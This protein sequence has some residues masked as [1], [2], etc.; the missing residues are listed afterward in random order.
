MAGF[1]KDGN[2][3]P[4][5][6][7]Y[8][9]NDDI[10][11]S[12]TGWS[13]KKV[14]DKLASVKSIIRVDAKPTYADGT[15]TYVKDGT[16]YTTTDHETWFYYVVNDELYKT[17]FI[18]GVEYTKLDSSVNFDDFIEKTDIVTVLD[19]T[20]TNKQVVGAK[21]VYEMTKDNN[22]KT[23]TTLDQLGLS[24]GCDVTEIVNTM[25]DHS[26]AEIGCYNAPNSYGL[27]FVTGL[28]N[29]ESNF[30]LTIRKYNLHR[31][32]I[33][34]KSSASGAVMNDLYIGGM[35][36]GGT[37]V[38][39]RNVCTTSVK[40]VTLVNIPLTSDF[41]TSVGAIQYKVVNGM[42][43]L[44]VYAVCPLNSGQVSIVGFPREGMY[45]SEALILR[46]ASTGEKMS[47]GSA[48]EIVNGEL[49]FYFKEG[50]KG[51]YGFTSYPVADD[52]RP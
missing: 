29:G 51:Y 38:S 24:S 6:G 47:N 13:S 50:G 2:L 25:P 41:N 23:F 15:I 22:I 37:S 1:A 21:T 36:A 17:T 12:D 43:L 35:V 30:I 34:A 45:A 10:V 20:V 4:T 14:M 3:Y 42:C 26:Y 46:D 40:D 27:E 44:T 48:M 52:W 18:D 11:S 9:I 33:Q 5:G 32:D 16:S 28:P 8:G 19:A 49:K 7:V 39:W 31:V